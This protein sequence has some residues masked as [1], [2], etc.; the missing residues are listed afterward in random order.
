MNLSNHLAAFAFVS[1]EQDIL[2]LAELF[3]QCQD[4]SEGNYARIGLMY[5]RDVVKMSK[6]IS[7]Y[8]AISNQIKVFYK[9]YADP[10]VASS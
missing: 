9:N 6:L 3:I 5:R 10:P 2:L 7:G 4:S 8:D 1:F